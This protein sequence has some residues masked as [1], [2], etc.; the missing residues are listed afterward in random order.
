MYRKLLVPLDGSPLAEQV[1]PYACLVARAFGARLELL[2]TFA[3]EPAELP[4]AADQAYVERVRADLEQTARGDLERTATALRQ[5][6][7]DV[8]CTVEEGRPAPRIIAAA[9]REPGTLVAMATHGRS[10]LTRWLVG[11]VTDKVLR[12]TAAP[13]LVVRPRER[14]AEVPEVHFATVVVPLDGSP[15]AEQALPHAVALARALGSRVVLLRAVPPVYL[16]YMEYAG[17][18]YLG[19]ATELE[20]VAAEYL[21]RVGRRLRRQGVAALEERVVRGDAAGAIVD[22]ARREPGTLVAMT[23][24]G[25]S[26]VGRWVLGSVTDRVVRHATAPVLVVRA[27]PG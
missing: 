5:E 19:S 21:D 9:E 11:S 12:G 16:G 15:L 10:G 20:E 18:P 23:T 24:H 26:G 22:Q 8:S 6:G 2:R 4:R 3:V 25:R 17:H 14:G 1:L 13:L 27:L 7:L